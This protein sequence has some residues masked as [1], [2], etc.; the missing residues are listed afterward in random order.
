M[1]LSQYIKRGQRATLQLL[2]HQ[3]GLLQRCITTR[4]AENLRT[5]AID[6]PQ[7]E[8]DSQQ[9][10]EEQNNS[11]SVQQ[12]SHHVDQ[13][14]VAVIMLAISCIILFRIS[15]NS[16]ELCSNFH[17]LFSKLFPRS[18]SEQSRSSQND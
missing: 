8:Q 2:M 15:C 18:L 5:K 11:Q 4:K 12:H 16:S 9:Y 10:I 6:N 3:K 13:D 7:V 1:V 17:A 14:R